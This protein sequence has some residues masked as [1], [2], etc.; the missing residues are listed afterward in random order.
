MLKSKCQNSNDKISSNVKIQMTKPKPYYLSFVLCHSFVICALSFVI[1]FSNCYAQPVSS[2]ELINN[3]KAYD[4]KTVAYAGEAIGDVMARGDFAWVNLNDGQNAIGIWM[5]KGSSKDILYTGSYKSKGDI[6][7]VVGV[8]HRACLQ[9]GGDLDIH[10]Q[11][12]RKISSGRALTEKLNVSKRNFTLVLL[13]ILCLV[14]ILRQ[15][16]QT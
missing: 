13:G 10:A 15:L 1:F 11:G 12:L 8:F 16:K 3:A 6:F 14:L 7:E 5:A 2:T 9:H 4:G